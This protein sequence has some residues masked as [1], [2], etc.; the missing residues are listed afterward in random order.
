MVSKNKNAAFRAATSSK[1]VRASLIR[2]NTATLTPPEVVE[3]GSV[4]LVDTQRDTTPDHPATRVSDA[5]PEAGS[6]GRKELA[7][8]IRSLL[9]SD[10]NIGVSP[11]VAVKMISALEKVIASTIAAGTE[12]SLPGFG[13]FRIN[14]RKGGQR[15]NPKTGDLA[16]V[17]P[18][19]SV[20][21][22]VG[23]SL[24]TAVNSRPPPGTAMLSGKMAHSQSQAQQEPVQ[25]A[26]NA[27]DAPLRVRSQLPGHGGSTVGSPDETLPMI[28]TVTED[29][30]HPS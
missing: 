2:K 6:H 29:S 20:A 7:E 1:Q 25:A 27:E 5:A 23:T 10:D 22:K 24:K 9:R 19:W 11:V 15:R 12:V 18:S 3:G 13:K 17:G 28:V 4:A 16:L 30:T 26:L 21:F 8:G 14:A